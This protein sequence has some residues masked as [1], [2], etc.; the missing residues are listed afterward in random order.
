MKN[1]IHGLG[2]ALV[3]P[4][5]DGGGIDLEALGKLVDSVSDGGVDYL[6][7]LGTTAETPTLSREEKKAVLDCVRTSN[8]KNLPIVV[9]IGGNCTENV[10]REIHDTDLTDVDAILSV[11]PYYNK[12]NQE[13]LFRHFQAVAEAAPKPL[14]LY[15]VPGRTGVNM[16][17]ETTLRLAREV[18]NIM[19]IKEACGTIQQM[20]HLVK[21]R[22]EN[23]R[24]ISGDDCLAL[25]LIAIG[26][27]GVISVAAN[28]YP[29]IFARM[30]KAGYEGD[31]ELG[32]EIWARVLNVVDCC[33]AEGNPVGVKAALTMQGKIKNL[34]RLPLVPASV[35]LVD[36]LAQEIKKS[37]L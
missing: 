9:G 27:D 23:F 5:T 29:D 11:T 14:M 35:A 21:N 20:S 10:I 13:G 7:A 32:A 28:A 24:V 12:P 34:L 19:G 22:P 31:T 1:N 30:I 17:A 36:R 37:N 33:F 18:G 8:R 2:V 26:G 6:V 4:F 3:T 15:N 16:T 25:A